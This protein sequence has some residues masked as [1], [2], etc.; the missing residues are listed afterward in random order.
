MSLQI[1]FLKPCFGDAP[2]LQDDGGTWISYAALRNQSEEWADRLSGPRG[3]VFIYIR[4][5]VKSVAALL[6]ALSAG[7]AVA[8][9]DPHLPRES[10][11]QLEALY[12]PDWLLETDCQSPVR[13]PLNRQPARLDPT[14]ALLLSTSGSTGSPKLV[15][16]T[17][18]AIEAN[19]AGIA[20]VLSIKSYDV[21]AGHLPLHY[22]FG[23]SVLTSHLIR[24]ARVH[25]TELGLMQR[26][27]WPSL[28]DAGITHFPGVP[29]HYHILAKLGFDRLN[30]GSLR[31]MTQ[32]GGVLDVAMRKQA[33]AFM[34]ERGGSFYVLYGQTEAAPRMATLQH[35]DFPLAEG[36]VG[37]P[38]PGCSFEILKPDDNGTGEVV[39]RGPNVM[40]GYAESKSDLALGDTLKG[41][42]QTGDIG[43][44]HSSGH[45]YLTGRSNRF[46]KVYGLRV[47]LDEIEREANKIV[48][49]AVIQVGEGVSVFTASQ[50]DQ[51]GDAA[52]SQRLLDNLLS[53]FTIPRTSYSIRIIDAIP[54]TK[55]GKVDYVAL[56]KLV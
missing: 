1:P 40:L 8:L 6:G 45:L 26:E 23:L 10:R 54:H 9:F 52:Q 35:A 21:A 43:R 14:L 19:A 38:L 3:L 24:G 27:F 29:F 46:G 4:N 5:N 49:T 16:L 50:G 39:F 53:R 55:R 20:E 13:G 12:E 2:A 22:S 36:S 30:L 18:R 7:H 15:R 37:T 47:N 28:R 34:S 44:L 17:L 41:R 33:H 56:G 32:A 42:L 25:L 31:T 48:P 11:A 51:A